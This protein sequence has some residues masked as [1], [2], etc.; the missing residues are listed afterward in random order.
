[1]GCLTGIELP[2]EMIAILPGIALRR[3]YVDTFGATMMA[4]PSIDAEVASSSTVGW[5]SRWL[6]L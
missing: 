3:V 5:C 6:Q 2:H 4:R 1:M